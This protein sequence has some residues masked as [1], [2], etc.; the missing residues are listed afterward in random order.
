MPPVYDSS[1]ASI[2]N[3]MNQ[4]YE[5]LDITDPM[6]KRDKFANFFNTTTHNFVCGLVRPYFFIIHLVTFIKINII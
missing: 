5:T 3:A 4:A 1:L 6:R 2:F